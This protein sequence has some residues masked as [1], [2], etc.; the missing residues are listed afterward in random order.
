MKSGKRF[1]FFLIPA[2]LYLLASLVTVFVAGERLRDTAIPQGIDRNSP[3]T[4]EQ[5]RVDLNRIEY[6]ELCNIP[7]IGP[8]LAERILE[9]RSEHGMFQ[10]VAELDSVPGIGEKKLK[11]LMEYVY[12]ED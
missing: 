2:V 5:L 4:V 8:A 6:D 12:V 10:A 11:L 3:A 9:Y 1:L 7:D